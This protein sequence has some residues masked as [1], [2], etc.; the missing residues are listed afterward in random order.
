MSEERP[1]ARP[2]PGPL[3]VCSHCGELRPEEPG[4]KRLDE[5]YSL[6]VCRPKSAEVIA[7]FDVRRVALTE[8]A[9]STG[10]VA[11][12]DRHPATRQR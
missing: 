11:L 10:G 7:G 6:V 3:W 4:Y 2:E 5:R 8:L 1:K 12:G 9:I